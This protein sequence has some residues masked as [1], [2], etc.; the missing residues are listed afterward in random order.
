M[1]LVLGLLTVGKL[2]K[3][4]LRISL[5]GPV[6]GKA[7]IFSPWMQACPHTGSPVMGSESNTDEWVLGGDSKLPEALGRQ[8][9]D[10]GLAVSPRLTK[11]DFQGHGSQEAS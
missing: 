10:R 11:V 6:A 4:F 1:L 9:V 8:N 5:Q 3:P 7:V 2:R